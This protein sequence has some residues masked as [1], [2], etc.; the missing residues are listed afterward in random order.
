MVKNETSIRFVRDVKFLEFL[1]QLSGLPFA[2]SYDEDEEDSAPA[3]RGPSGPAPGT[4]PSGPAPGTGPSGPAP[5]TGPSGPGPSSPPPE[6]EEEDTSWIVDHRVDD[7]GTEWAQNE[8]ET[9]Y[10]KEPGQTDW[11][12]WED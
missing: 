8:D 7:D 6:A 4:G 3:A 12:I 5:G 1:Y 2:A 9:W 10:F 11:S